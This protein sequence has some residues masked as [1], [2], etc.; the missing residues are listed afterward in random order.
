[1]NV[2]HCGQFFR[3]SSLRCFAA[4]LACMCMYMYMHY[5]I[6]LSDE[7]MRTFQA[8]IVLMMLG[9]ASNSV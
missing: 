9:G 6:L 5:S 3:D 1:M 7:S 2:L 4:I 8:G